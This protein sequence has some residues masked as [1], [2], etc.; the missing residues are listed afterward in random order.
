MSWRK[1]RQVCVGGVKQVLA[2]AC[3]RIKKA[4][5]IFSARQRL[6]GKFPLHYK[7][8]LSTDGQTDI[9]RTVFDKWRDRTYRKSLC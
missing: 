1:E 2:S 5:I 6:K 3:L 9:S 7:E 4:L 8:I